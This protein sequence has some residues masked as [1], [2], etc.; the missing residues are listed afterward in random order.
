MGAILGRLKKKKT[1]LEV[2]ESLENDIKSI[3]K[4]RQVN[5][6]TQRRLVGHLILFSVGIYVIAAMVFYFF[7]FPA[8]LKDQLFYIIPLLIFPIIVVLVR[9]LITWWY[10]RKIT[11]SQK[12]L[13]DMRDEKKRLLEE[14]MDKET[15]KVAKK[16]LDKFAP[17]PTR[18]APIVSPLPPVRSS[19]SSPNTGRQVALT[20]TQGSAT[21]SGDLR[22][23]S[24]TAQP[25]GSPQQNGQTNSPG[26]IGPPL[27]RPILPRE[28]TVLDKLVEYLVG[29]GP[30]NRY[31][32]ICKQCASHN[33]MALKEEFD[34]LSFRCCYCHFWNAARKQRPQAPR[35][36]DLSRSDNGGDHTSESELE[37][38]S[39]TESDDGP[40]T[41][42]PERKVADGSSAGAVE[43][44]A[45]S[46]TDKESTSTPSDSPKQEK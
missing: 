8:K 14:V 28:R 16:I 23:R 36:P 30:S 41:S 17:E 3:E 34:F 19:S 4:N 24:N 29:D 5:E 11:R 20:G 10:S 46:H 25:L 39:D 15:Y 9:R 22:R 26:P 38:P 31:A 42:T 6:Q 37:S 12:K 32:L 45:T 7:F 2:L 27:P 21:P 40:I 44:E 1:N 35:L 13:S 43:N 33:G 18:I